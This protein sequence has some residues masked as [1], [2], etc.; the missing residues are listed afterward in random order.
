[1]NLC[2]IPRYH[3]TC[4][5][6]HSFNFIVLMAGGKIRVFSTDKLNNLIFATSNISWAPSLT[7]SRA[8]IYHFWLEHQF[9]KKK[10]IS[11][12]LQYIG[13]WHIFYKISCEQNYKTDLIKAVI[14]LVQFKNYQMF[15]QF[16]TPP[17]NKDHP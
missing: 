10:I 7:R 15:S 11:T 9:N 4:I 2:R 12:I 1:M 13:V 3:C 5:Y 8:I 6:I 17:N 14:S 16:E